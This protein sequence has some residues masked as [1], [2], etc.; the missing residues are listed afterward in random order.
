[1]L[2]SPK[3]CVLDRR[4]YGNEIVHRKQYCFTYVRHTSNF[5]PRPPHPMFGCI[6]EKRRL[7]IW[8]LSI[9]TAVT[10]R[11]LI[12]YHHPLSSSLISLTRLT[13]LFLLKIS[14]CHSVPGCV[15]FDQNVIWPGV[16]WPQRQVPPATPVHSHVTS[17]MAF[18][19]GFTCRLVA[20]RLGQ[21]SSPRNCGQV[22]PWSN[23]ILV[24]RRAARIT[25]NHRFG[26]I[27]I[28]F[29]DI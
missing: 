26:Q 22:S 16:I 2:P 4:R 14:L 27:F 17:L 18:S 20:W 9:L 29:I 21:M 28:D 10:S 3:K 24:R 12:R 1:M 19:T 15:S 23:D 25:F 13:K 5:R 6:K 8:P 7:V 11:I